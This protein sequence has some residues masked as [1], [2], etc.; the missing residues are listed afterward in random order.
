MGRERQ[1][2]PALQKLTK[3]N[4]QAAQ[5]QQTMNIVR[6]IESAQENASEGGEDMNKVFYRLAM[7]QHK[8]RIEKKRCLGL[9]LGAF[10]VV[11]L[12]GP[13]AQQVLSVAVETDADIIKQ[14]H[15]QSNANVNVKN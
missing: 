15:E 10:C 6:A 1:N 13:V 14:Q 7:Q 12:L 3:R 5:E 8:S 2:R 9:F 4:Q 11:V